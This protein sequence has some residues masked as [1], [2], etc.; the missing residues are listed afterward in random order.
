VRSRRHASRAVGGVLAGAGAGAL[1]LALGL[2]AAGPSAA[3]PGAGADA[4]PAIGA[5]ARDTGHAGPQ[6]APD[7]S[8]DALFDRAASAMAEGDHA[9]AAADFVHLAESHP[10]H[11]LAAEALFSAARLYEERL[12][13]PGR[14]LA[15]YRTLAERHPDSR[16][17]L[18]AS[19]R[20][21]DIERQL[22]P[23]GG[24]DAALARFTE[25][26]QGFS[27]RAGAGPGPEDDPED[28]P[29]AR[30]A[31]EMASIAAVE[32][33]LA[34]HPTWA[35][36]PRA[37]LW[38]AEIHRRAGRNRD[39]LARYLQAA[40]DWPS[41][42]EA[43]HAWRGAGDMAARLDRFD[44]AERHY[45]SIPVASPAAQRSRDDA[46]ADLARSR[47]RERV[48]VT[49]FAILAAVIIG[50]LASL[51][52]ATGSARA[53]LR[54]LAR[55]PIEVMFMLPIA[56]LLTAGSFTGHESI[57][58]AVTLVCAGGVFLTWLSGAGLDAARAP[59]SADGL[60]RRRPL[61]HAAAVALAVLALCYIALHRGHLVDMILETV[62]F[63]PDV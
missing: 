31:A 36:T 10:A 49:C 15:L 5:G 46:L 50:L 62:R 58:P 27:G 39:A 28:D 37:L 6:A 3:A 57:G 44:E 53:A 17:A 47:L 41:S 59:D 32:A 12:A 30:L 22:D 14:A 52:Q 61:A 60:R 51:R 63:G 26:L 35:G 8:P 40:R 25:I 56:A 4:G 11:P 42:D 19:R 38:L 7:A 55:V 9:R 16:T 34:E 21:A 13:Q 33:L 18:A 54:A 48:H 1:A 43:V 29:D 20:A 24:G 2:L 45:R 23:G